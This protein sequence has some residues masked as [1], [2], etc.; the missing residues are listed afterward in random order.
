MDHFEP[1][2]WPRAW[3]SWVFDLWRLRAEWQQAQREVTMGRHASA[4]PRLEWLA[5]RWPGEAEVQYDLGLC[6]QALGHPDQAEK[7]WSAVRTDSPFAGR[8]AVMRARL[9]LQHHQLSVAEE[10]MPAALDD[11]GPH[12][13]EAR[14]TLIHIYK[15][16]GRYDEARRLVRDGWTRYPDR[17]GTLQELARLDSA[18]PI[19]IDK[20]GPTLETAFHAAPK[21]D[22]VWLG[23]ANLATRT[24][25][26][27]EARK[28]LD[29]CLASPA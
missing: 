22:R 10:L 13:I 5:K 8:A 26:F 27:A 6:E 4:L 3:E 7:A 20:V 29:A 14:E 17:V 25:R 24:G 1:D 18:T 15:I 16:Q 11:E 12:A 2:F 19:G 23:L 28:W 9:A 21:D